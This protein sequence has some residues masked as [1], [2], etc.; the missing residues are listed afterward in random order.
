LNLTI[1]R[2]LLHRL[3]TPYVGASDKVARYCSLFLAIDS[4]LIGNPFFRGYLIKLV[5]GIFRAHRFDK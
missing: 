4:V 3:K 5:C 1:N 2:M